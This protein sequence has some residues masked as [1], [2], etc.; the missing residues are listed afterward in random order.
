MDQGS[1]LRMVGFFKGTIT[2][3]LDILIA[4][5]CLT[6]HRR[7]HPYL[8]IYNLTPD[9]TRELECSFSFDN[10]FDTPIGSGL[11]FYNLHQTL[12]IS[13]NVLKSFT[14]IYCISSARSGFVFFI[15]FTSFFLT[16]ICPHHILS[17]TSCQAC[18]LVLEASLCS[19]NSRFLPLL[20]RPGSLVKGSVIIMAH[21][22]GA[23]AK[24]RWLAPVRRPLTF[25]ATS[26][27]QFY[28][29]PDQKLQRFRLPTRVSSGQGSSLA[30]LKAKVTYVSLLHL[31]IATSLA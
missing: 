12:N 9:P 17:G 11:K 15:S 29:T 25:S 1:S 24:Q 28:L 31:A 8:S 20:S 13:I 22:P 18:C 27:G 21:D 23:V 16:L 7:T 19:R 2:P 3:N 6:I 30:K 14:D 26:S 4:S 5:K 10:A